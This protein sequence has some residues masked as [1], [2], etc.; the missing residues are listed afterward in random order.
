EVTPMTCL[1]PGIRKGA[2]G[3][4]MSGPNCV[5]G[6]ST[7]VLRK[8][9]SVSSENH[10]TRFEFQELRES[11]ARALSHTRRLPGQRVQRGAEDRQ[12]RRR[13]PSGA[14]PTAACRG[15]SKVFHG[16][17][18]MD[19][20]GRQPDEPGRLVLWLKLCSLLQ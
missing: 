19:R 14:R 20:A 15:Q 2:I 9:E 1:P 8:I 7:F 18:T 11:R 10:Y 13:P 12:P 4:V 3:S 6:D 17:P 5:A 16:A